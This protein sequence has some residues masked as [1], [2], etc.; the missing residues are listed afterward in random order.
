VQGLP[1]IVPRGTKKEGAAGLHHKPSTDKKAE[2]AETAPK[3]GLT[4]IEQQL[5]LSVNT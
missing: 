2:N 5:G 4:K 1:Q 3:E